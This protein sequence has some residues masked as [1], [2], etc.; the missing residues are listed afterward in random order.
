M[1]DTML[2]ALCLALCVVVYI[3]TRW[4]RRDVA[5]EIDAEWEQYL[6]EIDKK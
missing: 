2:G 1:S 6:R 3:V 4:L 5:D